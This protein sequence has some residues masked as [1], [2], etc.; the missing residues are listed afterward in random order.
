VRFNQNVWNLCRRIPRGR[1]TTYKAIAEAVGTKAYQAV[2]NALKLNPNAP[3]VPC[4]RVVRSDLSLGGYKG[5]MENK[6]IVKGRKVVHPVYKVLWPAK[7]LVPLVAE[8]FKFKAKGY[9]DDTYI[10]LILAKETQNHAEMQTFGIDGLGVPYEKSRL[11]VLNSSP[12]FSGTQESSAL[13]N[14]T[15]P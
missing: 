10:G 14:W 7:L 4:H 8:T 9:N 13:H 6:E 15:A 12:V 5:K 3:I 2:G 11:T 1:V